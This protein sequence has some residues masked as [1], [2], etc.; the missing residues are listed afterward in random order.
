VV[1]RRRQ[2]IGELD[3]GRNLS[4]AARI[5]PK[6]SCNEVLSIASREHAFD[7]GSIARI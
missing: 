5:H 3:P 4:H 1:W 7:G 6:P 2:H